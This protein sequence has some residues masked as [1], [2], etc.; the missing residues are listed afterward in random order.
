MS[1]ICISGQTPLNRLDIIL[2]RSLTAIVAIFIIM[3]IIA[4]PIWSIWESIRK[5][6]NIKINQEK[7]LQIKKW[8]EIIGHDNFFAIFWYFSY[9]EGSLAVIKSIFLVALFL[10]F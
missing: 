9:F 3:I 1:I 5:K 2:E 4:K 8:K 7:G 10:C 6:A